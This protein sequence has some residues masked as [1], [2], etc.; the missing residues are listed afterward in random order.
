M[1][2]ENK[3]HRYTAESKA[4]LGGLE[5]SEIGN[6]ETESEFDGGRGRRLRESL[7]GV[8]HLPHFAD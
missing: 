6:T 7:G 3:Y 4:K 1:G 5:F 2:A 8:L